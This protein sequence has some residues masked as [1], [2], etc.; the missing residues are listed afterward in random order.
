MPEALKFD[1]IGYWSEVKLEI[2]GKYATAYSTIRARL[3]LAA[4]ENATAPVA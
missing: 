3:A 2:L 1:E 4:R